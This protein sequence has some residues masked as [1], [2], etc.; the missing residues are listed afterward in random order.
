MPNYLIPSVCK[1][2]EKVNTS[3]I[4]H[5]VADW[6]FN[7]IDESWKAGMCFFFYLI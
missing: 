4:K 2:P 7:K 3:P 1:T 6:A 5:H